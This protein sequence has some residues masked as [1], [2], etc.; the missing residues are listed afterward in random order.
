MTR[1]RVDPGRQQVHPQCMKRHGVAVG[2]V[3]TLVLVP[4]GSVARGAFPGRN[5]RIAFMS[6]RANGG[7]ELYTVNEDGSELER[8]TGH[9]PQ[10][11]GDRPPAWSPDGRSMA[12]VNFA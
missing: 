11:Y 2:L 4:A 6:M 7:V 1:V 3:L 10:I 12:I 9:S 5:G 8:L